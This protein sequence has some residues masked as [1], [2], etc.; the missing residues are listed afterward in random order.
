MAAIVFWKLTEQPTAK[1]WR[2][3]AIRMITPEQKHIA[4]VSYTLVLGKIMQ[5]YLRFPEEAW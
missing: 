4:A 2:M 3:Q 5:G 1:R